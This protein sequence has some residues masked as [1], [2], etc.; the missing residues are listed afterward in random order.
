[1]VIA[2]GGAA[3]VPVVGDFGPAEEEVDFCEGFGG[4]GEIGG[5]LEG[6]LDEVFE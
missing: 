6:F 1:M 2:E 3:V 5:F 4:L